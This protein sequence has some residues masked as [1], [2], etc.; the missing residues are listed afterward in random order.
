MTSPISVLVA[1]VVVIFML[2]MG[3][4]PQTAATPRAQDDYPAQTATTVAMLTATA[5]GYVAPTTQSQATSAP[6]VGSSNS[7]TSTPTR[8]V[9]ATVTPT[10]TPTLEAT[11]TD[12]VEEPVPPTATRAVTPTATPSDGLACVPGEP[13]EIAGEG[14]PRA[15]YLLF[16]GERPVGGGTV[17]PDGTFLAKLVVGQERAGSYDVTVRVRGTQQVLR[18]VTC[19]IPDVTPTPFPQLSG[20]R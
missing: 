13:I 11:A 6:T 1:G 14:P 5:G 10:N 3:A 4:D 8:T 15:A 7:A 12:E 20:F 16:F 17:E 19:A 2:L 9:T 18:E